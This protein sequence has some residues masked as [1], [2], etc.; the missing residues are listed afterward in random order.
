MLQEFKQWMPKGQQLL[1]WGVLIVWMSSL[2]FL[3]FSGGKLGALMFFITTILTAYLLLLARW[4]GI[5]DIVGKRISNNLNEKHRLETGDSIHLKTIFSIPGFWPI[6]YIFIRD[7][8]IHHQLG[9]KIY[10]SSFV[11]DFDRNGYIEFTVPDLMR[12]SYKFGQTECSTGDLLNLFE[13]KSFLNLPSQFNVY[14]KTIR[15]RE[16]PD[17]SLLKK[18]I[19]RNAS[20]SRYQKETNQI[21][22]VRE[23]VHGD[24]LSRIHWNASAKTGELKSKEFI[25]ESIPKILLI[26]DQFYDAYD[27]DKQFELA[28]SATASMINYISKQ[29]I[30]VGL[31]SP[32]KKVRYFK[33]K[34]GGANR[35]R[36]EDHLL[37]VSSDGDIPIQEALLNQRLQRL[38]G[39]LVVVIT[40]VADDHIFH[41]LRWLKKMKLQPCHILLSSQASRENEKWKHRLQVEQIS[42]YKIRSL[43]ELPV[44]LRGSN[45]ESSG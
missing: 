13:H 5:N 31:F 36:L 19:F 40:P 8:L 42:S 6:P 24:R 4:S 21:D 15:I 9:T 1:F 2:L 45:H 35:H 22:G 37:Y 43:E 38:Q 12:G 7:Q 27:D 33:P 16:W 25:R 41:R 17:V 32:G 23:Y 11:P 28:V 34:H 18:S 39:S 26:I 20:A 44:A 10:Q 29:Q 14:P 30:P 3:L